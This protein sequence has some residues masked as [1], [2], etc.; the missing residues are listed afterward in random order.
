MIITKS[1][2][3]FARNTLDY[4]N[5]VRKLKDIGVGVIFEKENINTLDGKG[6]VL[7]SILA[8]LLKTRVVQ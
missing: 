3:R 8:S 5:F 4:L 2:A 1:I 7:I 6:E